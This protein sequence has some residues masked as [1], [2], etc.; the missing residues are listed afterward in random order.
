MVLPITPAYPVIPMPV[1]IRAAAILVAAGAW[2]VAP[3][4][5]AVPG[6]EEGTLFVSYTRGAGGGAMDLQIQVS[7]YSADQ[8][9]VQS[10]FPMSLYASG[11]LAAGSDTQSRTQREY[12]TYQATGAAIENFIHGPFSLARNIERIRVNCR[13]SGVVGT[14]GTVH[15]VALF[16]WGN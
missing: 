13:E 14:P 5:F 2:D 10:W 6:F 9:V 7:P 8:L 4:E 1:T 16:G 15:I 3:L 11:I 12:I